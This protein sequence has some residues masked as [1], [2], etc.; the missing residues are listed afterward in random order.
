MRKIIANKGCLV[1]KVLIV[2]GADVK[3]RKYSRIIIENFKEF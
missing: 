3:R 2:A 1:S